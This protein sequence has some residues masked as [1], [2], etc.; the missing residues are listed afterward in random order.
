MAVTNR[1]AGAAYNGL[2]ALLAF[3]IGGFV[4]PRK[5]WRGTFPLCGCYTLFFKFSNGD[6]YTIGIYF[7]CLFFCLGLVTAK[8]KECLTG[9][10]ILY[11]YTGLQATF[12][13]QSSYH[14]PLLAFTGELQGVH[15][16]V[17]CA[18]CCSSGNPYCAVVVGCRKI[19]QS[20]GQRGYRGG[21]AISCVN[22]QAFVERGC[23][24][25]S[26]NIYNATRHLYTCSVSSWIVN[27]LS[28]VS[29]GHIGEVASSI[30]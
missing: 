26:A 25:R 8:N 12:V 9:R 17:G 7:G 28:A 30:G 19:V 14:S 4:C 3:F 5:G 20:F 13:G 18:V 24:I 23:S 16:L 1:G 21:C 2:Y 6:I 27:F 10:C 29:A 22:E 11:G 15:I